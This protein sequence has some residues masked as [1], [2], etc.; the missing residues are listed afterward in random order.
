MIF[1]VFLVIKKRVSADVIFKNCNVSTSRA[2]WSTFD[3]LIYNTNAESCRLRT[4]GQDEEK[5]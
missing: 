1:L 4:I 3:I 5:Q 2:I